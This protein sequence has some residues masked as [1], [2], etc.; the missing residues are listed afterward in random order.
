MNKK[1]GPPF[2]DK[3]AQLAGP[4][5]QLVSSEG[6]AGT[7]TV[8]KIVAHDNT[9]ERPRV[10]IEVYGGRWWVKAK[11]VTDLGDG[12]LHIQWGAFKRGAMAKARRRILERE[13]KMEREREIDFS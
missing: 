11:Y 10:N 9:N 5:K 3:M 8:G 2:W 12:R 6:P 13:G 7:I 4:C 1:G